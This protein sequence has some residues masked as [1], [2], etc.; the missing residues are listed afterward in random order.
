MLVFGSIKFYGCRKGFFYASTLFLIPEWNKAN[1]LPKRKRGSSTDTLQENC[2]TFIE[3]RWSEIGSVSL[4]DIT[5]AK[6]FF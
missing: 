3:Q 6:V 5:P 1:K 4:S 2:G